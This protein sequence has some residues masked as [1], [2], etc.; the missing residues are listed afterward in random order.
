MEKQGLKVLRFSNLQVLQSTKDVLDV[1][2]NALEL[3][4]SKSK[5]D[6]KIPLNPPFSKG[7][8]AANLISV[9]F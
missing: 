5:D 3:Q 1:I 7:E 4:I 9:Y 6:L 8:T 2:F